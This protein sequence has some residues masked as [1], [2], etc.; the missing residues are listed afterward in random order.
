MSVPNQKIVKVH[1][2]KYNSHFLQ[3]GISEWQEA[4]KA[5]CQS[6][7]ALYLYLAGNADGFNLELSQ[8]AFENATGYKKSS[9]H[10]ALKKLE[11]LGY[12][13]QIQGNIWGFYTSPRRDNG[14][15]P[16]NRTFS[17]VQNSGR[18][19]PL[20]QSAPSEYPNKRDRPANIEID[21]IDKINK[22]NKGELSPDGDNSCGQKPAASKEKWWRDERDKP[23]PFETKAEFVERIRRSY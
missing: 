13:I 9:Y 18:E 23:K 21:N 10:D 20:Q 5:M 6:E 2:S 14:R 15:H 7:F 4:I 17:E 16:L 11:R 22:I 3:I 8:K 1:K 12:L 19:I